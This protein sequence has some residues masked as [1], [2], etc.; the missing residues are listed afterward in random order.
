MPGDEAF[1]PSPLLTLREALAYRT[2]ALEPGASQ[3]GRTVARV[4]VTDREGIERELEAEPG[5][6]LMEVLREAG[7]PIEALCG[8]CCACSTCHVYVEEDW[9]ARLAPPRQDELDTLEL[10]FDVLPS[11][12]LSCQIPFSESLDGIRVRLGPA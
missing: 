2:P 7:L 12:R 10:A 9:L 4:Y 3:R 8:G 6:P 5:R 11:S 1:G